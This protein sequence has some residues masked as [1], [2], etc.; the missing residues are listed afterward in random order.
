M[1]KPHTVR[2][3]ITFSTTAADLRA[4]A[5]EVINRMQRHKPGTQIAATSLAL[6]TMA[7]AIGLDPHELIATAKRMSVAAEG[8]YSAE[9]KAIRAYAQNEIGRGVQL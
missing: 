5:F 9:I 1:F 7:E 8:I 6:V 2:D 4:P 3:Q